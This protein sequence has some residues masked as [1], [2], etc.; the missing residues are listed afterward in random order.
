[1]RRSTG[2]DD[3]LREFLITASEGGGLNFRP[4][5]GWQTLD[6]RRLAEGRLF[7]SGHPGS[8]APDVRDRIG[9]LGVRTV[10]TFQT[11]QELE[12]LGDPRPG[13]LC[14]A[15]WVHIPVGDQWFHA[16]PEEINAELLS[17]GEFYLRMVRDHPGA[18]RR[19]F[20]VLADEDGYSVLYH[21]TAGRDR[22]GVATL[23]LLET[24]GVPRALIA[25]DYVR[26]N[27]VFSGSPKEGSALAELF[28][29]IDAEGGI[30]STLEKHL[31]I[32]PEAVASVRRH[33]LD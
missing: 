12:V 29:W 7:R 10:V 5:S 15:R 16:T 13:A 32:P 17:T 11:R 27:E 24:L 22:T 21:C 20:E 18:W 28:E 2:M 31:G 14:E 33:L 30:E 9:S 8:L 4:V 1:M 25:A 23:L 3:D 19:F 6:G 26:S